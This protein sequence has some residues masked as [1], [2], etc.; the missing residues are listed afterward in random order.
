[1]AEPTGCGGRRLSIGYCRTVEARLAEQ[2]RSARWFHRAR[3]C[4]DEQRLRRGEVVIEQLPASGG[5]PGA[6]LH[7]WRGTAFAPGATA[8]DFERLMRDFDAYPQHFSPQVL[9]AKTVA[10][11]GDHVQAWMRVRQRHVITVVMDT[12]LRRHVWAAGC[13]AWIQHLAEHADRGDRRGGHG[14]RS[15]G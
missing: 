3:R 11:E 10:Q 2:H 1:M 7:D 5:F 9:E 8:A 14:R 13:A 12:T 15:V 6:M 4:E